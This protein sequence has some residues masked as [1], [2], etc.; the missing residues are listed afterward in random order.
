MKTSIKEWCIIIHKKVI[1]FLSHLFCVVFY[2]LFRWY[3][4]IFLPIRVLLCFLWFSKN[5]F[6]LSIF[7]FTLL[8]DVYACIYL[9][10]KLL[11]VVVLF[12][13]VYSVG[14]GW[15]FSIYAFYAFFCV[16]CDFPRISFFFRFFCLRCYTMYMRTY[17]QWKRGSRRITKLRM[18]A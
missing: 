14:M 7:L 5:F 11:F 9:Q 10:W 13:I 17:L 12:S 16:F 8:Y 4:M 15:F 6:F 3:G 2:C 18:G 1:K